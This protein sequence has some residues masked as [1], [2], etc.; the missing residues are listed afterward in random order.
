MKKIKNLKTEIDCL[1]IQLGVERERIKDLKELKKIEFCLDDL[2]KQIDILF[3]L[4]G[5]TLPYTIYFSS[6]NELNYFKSIYKSLCREVPTKDGQL[7]FD[8]CKIEVNPKLS[9]WVVVA[10]SWK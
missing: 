7:I 9:R 6:M 10:N 5:F 2:R 3:T 4:K 8:N 1:K